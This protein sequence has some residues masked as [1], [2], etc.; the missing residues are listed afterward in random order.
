MDSFQAQSRWKSISPLNLF[1]E[2][3]TGM[4]YNLLNE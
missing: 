1:I 3:D 2:K 4:V